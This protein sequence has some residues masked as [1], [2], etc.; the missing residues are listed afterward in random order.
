VFADVAVLHEA[1]LRLDA[2]LGQ[3]Y[4]R[5]RRVN[6]YLRVHLGSYVEGPVWTLPDLLDPDRLVLDDHLAI[7]A[8]QYKS[9]DMEVLVRFYFGGLAYYLANATAGPFIVDRR[10]PVLNQSSLGFSLSEWEAPEFIVLPDSRFHCLP[11]DPAADHGDA[12]LIA[13]RHAL[14]RLLRSSLVSV[15][16][17]VIAA[18]RRRARIGA[19]A[20]WISAAETCAAVLVDALPAATAADVAREEVRALIG[21]AQVLLRAKP[22][23]VMVASGDVSALATLGS[24]CCCNFKLAGA[25]YCGVCPHRPRQERLATLEASLAE[26]AAKEASRA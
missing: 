26:R 11:D 12:D 3:T 20:L 1:P 25:S 23:I 7:M 2:P 14:R 22:E 17:P 13:D 21:E 10:V 8:R 6:P 16:E 24:D 19:R 4:E 5:V 15:L 9:D 18:L